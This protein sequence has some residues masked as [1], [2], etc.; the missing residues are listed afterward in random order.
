[1]KTKK[2]TNSTTGSCMYY[3]KLIKKCAAVPNYNYIN[4]IIE[5]RF[6]KFS[7]YSFLS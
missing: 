2:N 7:K 6:K 5:N 4:A 3:Q 1:M